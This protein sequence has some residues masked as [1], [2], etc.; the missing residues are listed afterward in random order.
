[1]RVV[2]AIDSFK[3]SLS[4][5]EGGKVIETVCKQQNIEDVIMLPLADG[6]EG[7][8]DAFLHIL[9]G[10]RKTVEVLDPLHRQIQADYGW[11][12]ESKLAIIETAAASGLPLLVDEERDPYRTST[13]GTGQLV[14]DALDQGATDIIIGLGG[15]ATIDG[16]VGLLQA[17]GVVF[18]LEDGTKLPIG[19]I[20]LEKISSINIDHMDRRLKDKQLFIASDVTNPLVG[21]EGAVYVFGAQKGLQKQDMDGFD[22]AMDHYQRLVKE[23]L[24]RDESETPGAGA[25][26]GLGFALYAF[27]GGK[28]RS[29]FDL[30]C[31]KANLEEKISKADLVIT[32]EGKIDSQ[33]LYGKVPIGVSRIAKKYHVP[34]F[35]FT[36]KAEGDLT[37]AYQEGISS[38]IPI[39]DEVTT[40]EQAMK[41]APSYLERATRRTIQILRTGRAIQNKK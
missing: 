31:Q 14:K 29:G 9:G 34:V 13:Y 6:G 8:V 18:Y 19:D 30:I 28:F 4:S 24:G 40:L 10:V 16:G 17:L 23:T 37:D 38:I 20:H 12:E 2:I 1:M 39:I 22:Q 15:S 25:A 35:V 33:S 32:G 11:I 27:F 5:I 7:T 21:P 41:E 26:G 36:G 3:G